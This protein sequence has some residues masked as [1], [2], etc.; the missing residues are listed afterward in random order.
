M[1]KLSETVDVIKTK[2][3]AASDEAKSAT[4]KKADV[5]GSKL[6]DLIKEVSALTQRVKN[7]ES[8]K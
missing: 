7:L 5:A 2:V 4:R 3:G 6:A 8:R 1:V